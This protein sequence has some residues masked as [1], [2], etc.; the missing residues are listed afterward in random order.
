MNPLRKVIAGDEQRKSRIHDLRGNRVDLGGLVYGPRC[1]VEA[2]AWKV[3]GWRSERPWLSYRAVRDISALVQPTWRVLE[4]GSGMS[5]TWFARRCARV[6]SC[7]PD[8]QWFGVVDRRLAASGLQSKVDYYNSVVPLKMERGLTFD[9]VLVDGD[10][11]DRCIEIA[12]RHAKPGAVVYLDNT[13]F[14]GHRSDIARA[15]ALL[16]QVVDHGG[17]GRFYVDFVHAHFVAMQGLMVRLPR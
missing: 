5:T 1:L 10:E 11:R 13:D 4:F 2:V 9:F 14:A 12:L 6:V 17:E 16:L 15:E 8:S 3:A 7:E